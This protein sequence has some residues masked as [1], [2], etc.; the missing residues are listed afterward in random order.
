MEEPLNGIRI[1]SIVGPQGTGKTT[2]GSRL[3]L[4]LETRHIEASDYAKRITGSKQRSDLPGLTEKYTKENPDWLGQ[5]IEEVILEQESKTIIL[6]GVRERNVHLYLASRGARL[7]I[8]ELEAPAELRFQR[9][10]RLEKVSSATEFIEQ[11]LREIKLGVVDVCKDALHKVPN[12]TD[13]HP[14]KIARAIEK[15]LR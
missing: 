7:A 9:L 3:A 4:L 13:E 11:E 5:A 15:T 10:L 2:I 1:V 6:T 8:Y 14:G 12:S